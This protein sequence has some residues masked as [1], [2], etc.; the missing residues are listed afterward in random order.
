MYISLYIIHIIK[1]ISFIQFIPTLETKD[2]V[3]VQMRFYEL[4]M[5]IF[6][7]RL[8]PI[9]NQPVGSSFKT[10]A[11]LRSRQKT[12]LEKDGSHCEDASRSTGGF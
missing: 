5:E 1:D 9:P 4:T 8:L 10:S 11:N 2:A 3:V 12:W 6:S 7:A